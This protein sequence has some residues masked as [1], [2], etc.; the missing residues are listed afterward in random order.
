[1]LFIGAFIAALMQVLI[2][3]EVLYTLGTHPVLSVLA[4]LLLGFIVSMCSNVDAFFALAYSTSFTLGS[5]LTFMIFGPMIDIKILTMLRKT[6]TKKFLLYLTIIVAI[7]SA[8]VG[9][10]VNIWY[11]NF[12]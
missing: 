6:F 4:M 10:G 8:A 5:L 7:S 9:I 2:P 11:R 1:M 3:R 12:L